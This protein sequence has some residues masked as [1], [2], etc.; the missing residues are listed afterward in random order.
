MKTPGQH[1]RYKT[2]RVGGSGRRTIVDLD[3]SFPRSLRLIN[4]LYA[5]YR[6]PRGAG[7]KYHSISREIAKAKPGQ[8]VDHINGNTLDNRRKNLRICTNSQNQFNRRVSCNKT[9]YMGVTYQDGMYRSYYRDGGVTKH[10]GVFK[11][12]RGAA[13]A[14]KL[15]IDKVYG[16]FSPGIVRCQRHSNATPSK[17]NP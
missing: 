8:M 14:R 16:E 6:I 1:R 7:H 15:I 3:I 4:G 5:Y 13:L 9:G 10:V 12:A 2:L 17:G 11:T